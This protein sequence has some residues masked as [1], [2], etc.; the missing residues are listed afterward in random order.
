[1][2]I[3]WC[4]CKYGVQQCTVTE[5]KVIIRNTCVTI[6][7]SQ[8]AKIRNRPYTC[9]MLYLYNVINERLTLFITIYPCIILF[10][11]TLIQ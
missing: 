3:S 9:Y 2:L 8:C 10:W 4:V 1:M 6:R 7:A 5:K 11:A